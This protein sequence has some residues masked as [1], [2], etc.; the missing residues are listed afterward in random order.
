LFTRAEWQ[1][2]VSA[3]FAEGLRAVVS[4]VTAA[5]PVLQR[6]VPSCGAALAAVAGE[7]SLAGE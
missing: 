5:E 4:A 6:V 1:R 7:P 3:V 2:P